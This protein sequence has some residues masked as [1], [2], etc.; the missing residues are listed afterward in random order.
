MNHKLQNPD[1]DR[2]FTAMLSLETIDECYA[3]FE[4]LCT[5]SEIKLM[6]QRFKVVKMLDKGIPYSDIVKES[7][8]STAT[9]SRVN[10]CLLYGDGYRMM[11]NRLAAA[12]EK[13]GK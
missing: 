10:R 8:A 2:L 12:E 11:L 6:E 3:F 9:I 4:D 5:I 13:A 7:G 1:L